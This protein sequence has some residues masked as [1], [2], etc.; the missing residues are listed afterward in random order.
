MNTVQRTKLWIGSALALLI[1][2]T[3]GHHFAS[4]LN[5]P[6]ATWAAFFLAGFYFRSARTFALLL[7][8][9]VA[10]DFVATTVG[11]VS[12]YCL[13]PAYAFMLPA[14]GMLWL[15][16]RWF[17]GRYSLTPGGIP[18]LSASLLGSAL[19]AEVISS[20]SFYFLSGRFADTSLFGFGMGLVKYFP[21]SLSSF[22][23]WIG[24]ALVVHLSFAL[25]ASG[26][27]HH[28]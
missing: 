21:Q 27:Q 9:V 1:I 2:A 26:K 12:N 10:L 8:E 15:A 14:Y 19:F 11:G 28:A 7:A 24:V 16:G 23:F 17:A 13:T 22:T 3:H 20:G 18:A 6:P 4:L 25:T 5:L